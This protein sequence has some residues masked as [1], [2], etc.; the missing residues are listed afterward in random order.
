MGERIEYDN[1]NVVFLFVGVLSFLLILFIGLFWLG[2][3]RERKRRERKKER[4]NE[5]IYFK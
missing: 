2:I 1:L 4:E 3:E 5:N